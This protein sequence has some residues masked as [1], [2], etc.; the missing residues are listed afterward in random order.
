MSNNIPYPSLTP[1]KQLQLFY[2][3]NIYNQ[4]LAQRQVEA[5]VIYGEDF[6]ENDSWGDSQLGEEMETLGVQIYYLKQTLG[7]Y[8]QWN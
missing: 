1:K 3:L 6:I 5:Q 2:L 7:F 8:A 4:M